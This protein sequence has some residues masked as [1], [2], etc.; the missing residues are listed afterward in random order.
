MN[1]NKS[2]IKLLQAVYSCARDST[3]PL[4]KAASHVRTGCVPRHELP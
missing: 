1:I 3:T 4:S 2:D